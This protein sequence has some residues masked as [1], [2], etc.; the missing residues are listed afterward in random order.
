MG[1]RQAVRHW[2][3]IPTF[4]GSNPSTPAIFLNIQ[5]LSPS[6]GVSPSGKAQDFDSCIR[7]FKSSHPSHTFLVG[8]AQ[9]VRAPGCGPGGHEFESHYS[10][11][12]FYN[13]TCK[14]LDAYIVVCYTCKCALKLHNFY[15]PLAQQVEHLTF[16]QVVRSSNLRWITIFF[17]RMWRNWQTR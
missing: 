4:E 1:C 11:Q 2:I 16:N 3:L 5:L 6:I 15:D 8:I 10:P 17:T 13:F 9:L 14:T 12:Y 7:W